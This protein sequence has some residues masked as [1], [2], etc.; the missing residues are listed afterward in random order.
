MDHEKGGSVLKCTAEES[1]RQPVV[2]LPAFCEEGKG[3]S[4]WS[5]GGPVMTCG[6][7]LGTAAMEHL[8]MG[9]WG[10]GWGRKH[11]WWLGTSWEEWQGG[12]GS[13]LPRLLMHGT[14]RVTNPAVHVGKRA[15]TSKKMDVCWGKHRHCGHPGA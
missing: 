7:E 14:Q 6:W 12:Q 5:S 1:S 11:P 10:F 8:E 4:G 13:L 2:A 3:C 15:R 9:E